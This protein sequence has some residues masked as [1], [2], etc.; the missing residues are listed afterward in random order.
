MKQE[1][2]QTGLSAVKMNFCEHRLAEYPL[3]QVNSVRRH[4]PGGAGLPRCHRYAPPGRKNAFT[5]I[6]LL[7]VIAIISLLVS[8]LL[9]SLTK[10][11][12]LAQNTV[13]QTNQRN[14]AL[15]TAMYVSDNDERIFTD[16]PPDN[17]GWQAMKLIMKSSGI[18]ND[19]GQFEPFNSVTRHAVGIFRCPSVT[20]P[21]SPPPWGNFDLS[22]WLGNLSGWAW[23]AESYMWNGAVSLPK[24]SGIPWSRFLDGD[25]SRI[26]DP[27]KT[28]M[29]MDGGDAIHGLA[30][31]YW[32][33]WDP[34][35]HGR[36]GWNIAW[37]D[38]HV[39]WI[40]TD[41]VPLYNNQEG[42]GLLYYF[43]SPWDTSGF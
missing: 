23:V 39:D 36:D 1:T 25:T 30:P 22:N 8:I 11:K 24:A 10:A 6:E 29:W 14:I 4:K 17:Y 34:T 18:T 35:R 19:E 3:R 9:P 41:D 33:R 37:W 20:G 12:A 21:L 40:N 13:C 32:H 16:I 43:C 7:V 5:L 15:A 28:L 31:W 27:V 2:A 38:G 42:A 26:T